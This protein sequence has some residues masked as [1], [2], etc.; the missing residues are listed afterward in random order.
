MR[1]PSFK[2]QLHNN[3]VAIISLFVAIIALVLNTWRLEQTEKNRNVRQAGFEILKNL[4][5]LQSIVNLSL[6]QSD[7]TSNNS[8]KGWSYIAM[9]SDIVVLMPL[10]VQED[11][12]QL[13]KVWS[14]HWKKISTDEDSADQVT[15]QIDITREAVMKTLNSLH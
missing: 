5:E 7:N 8:I 15:L 2:S 11:L 14:I 6:Y 1:P 13:I 12:K 10:E 9:M 3:A 4:G